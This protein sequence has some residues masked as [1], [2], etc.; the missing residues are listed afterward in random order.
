MVTIVHDRNQKGKQILGVRTLILEKI[1]SSKYTIIL[2]EIGV[3]SSFRH[4]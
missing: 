3:K 2:H 4:R 1:L